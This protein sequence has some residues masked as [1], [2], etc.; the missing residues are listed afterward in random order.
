MNAIKFLVCSLMCLFTLPITELAATTDLPVYS[1]VIEYIHREYNEK[2]Q[3]D[4]KIRL[5]NGAVL[6]VV[7]FDHRDDNVLMT[8]SPGDRL[9]FSTTTREGQLLLKVENKGNA[10]EIGGRKKDEV[11]P[12]VIYDLIAS[13]RSGLKIEE[14]REDGKFVKLNNDSVWEF[15][16]FNRFSTKNWEPGQRVLLEGNGRH[17]HY[18]FINVDSQP[19]LSA[20][21][22][23][24][25]F[26]IN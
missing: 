20:Y 12:Y 3:L 8:W 19:T 24:G 9:S 10:E 6:N 25:S 4:A 26:V 1:N 13:S 21:E 16:F 18:H 15:G 11:V 5:D 17:N 14:V 7:D 22:A 2:N 23:K